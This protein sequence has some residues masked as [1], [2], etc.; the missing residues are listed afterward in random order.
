MSKVTLKQ[1]FLKTGNKKY[2]RTGA[3]VLELGSY[4]KK[5]VPVL[6]GSYLFQYSTLRFNEGDV[7]EI[8]PFEFDFN[9]TAKID[10][11]I[12]AEIIAAQGSTIISY[13]A[14]KSGSLVFIQ[15]TMSILPIIESLNADNSAID[16]LKSQ[17]RPRIVN[18][19]FTVVSA[20]FANKIKGS[21]ALEIN[22]TQNGIELSIKPKIVSN[23]EMKL[24]LPKNSTFAYGLVEPIWD[25]SRK[26]IV[27]LKPDLKGIG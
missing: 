11:N 21:G 4:G 26:K 14:L 17:Q 12:T 20:D 18:T 3:E 10:A 22:T 9:N 27:D 25:G 1:K 19:I 8:G 7:K 2:F 6:A 16:Y 24:V 15:F 5:E 23:S 13:E